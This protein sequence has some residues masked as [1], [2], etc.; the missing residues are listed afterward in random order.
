[1]IERFRSLAPS[2]EVV[3][4]TA[5]GR[6]VMANSSGIV[7]AW[8]GGMNQIFLRLPREL[9]QQAL[10]KMGRFD[11]TYGED[12]IEFPAFGQRWGSRMDSEEALTRWMGI[13]YE[14]S[15]RL[16]ADD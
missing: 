14:K 15:L 3:Q 7:F 10:E 9:Q 16:R 5:Y 6:P 12:W 11:P 13:A 4:G 1:L 8:A 2:A